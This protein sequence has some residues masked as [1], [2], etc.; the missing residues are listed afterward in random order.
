MITFTLATPFQVGTMTKPVTV[1]ALQVTGM[2]FTKTP[3]LAQ[4]GTGLLAITL[5]DPVSGWQEQITY[6]DATIPTIFQFAIASADVGV[7]V[8]DTIAKML[9][10]KL[11]AD[12][13]LPA[14]TI[15]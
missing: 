14:G 3:A 6:Q 13:K 7:T 8:E 5:T 11:V 15:S 4:L 10:A 2:N 12:S 9:L 1:S